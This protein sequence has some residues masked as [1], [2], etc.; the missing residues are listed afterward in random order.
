MVGPARRP[1]RRR[2]EAV[3][4]CA[5]RT[6]LNLN[7]RRQH[8]SARARQ[9][10]PDGE[11]VGSRAASSVAVLLV[12]HPAAGANIS[13][14]PHAVLLVVHGRRERGGRGDRPSRRLRISVPYLRTAAG[15][16]SGEVAAG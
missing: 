7:R 6:P 3:R 11:G 13:A 10:G 15:R 12:D 9:Q 8:L 4:R 5:L 14:P 1:G 16:E 2:V